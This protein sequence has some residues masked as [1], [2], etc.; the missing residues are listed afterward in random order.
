MAL[1]G[2]RR[3]TWRSSP[4]VTVK[5]GNAVDEG[6]TKRVN[7]AAPEGERDEGGRDE[8]EGGRDEGERD[9]DERDIAEA[10]DTDL[11]D[12]VELGPE[13]GTPGR[14]VPRLTDCFNPVPAGG[15]L[16]SKFGKRSGGWHAGQD[17]AP[18]RP[19][20]QGVAVHAISAGRVLTAQ[21][22]ALK[23]H[24]GLGVVIRHPSGISSYYGHLA[25]ARV[26]AGDTV[27][28]GQLVG[29]MGFTGNTRPAGAQGTHLHL[30]VIV[31]GSFVDPRSFLS[32]NG[33]VI[34]KPSSDTAPRP[35]TGTVRPDDPTSRLL[36]AGYAIDGPEGVVGAV[37]AYQRT[38]GLRDD[39]D[40][41][42]V[43]ERHYQFTR[44]LQAALNRWKAVRP[45][46]RV[47]GDLGT[48]TRQALRQMQGRNGL[49]VTGEPDAATRRRLEV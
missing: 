46:L 18:P 8:G 20:Q 26:S 6:S 44:R 41:G 4:A 13:W 9:E 3:Q 30:G 24:T 15:R 47:D 40:W 32:A 31:N 38:N 19:A 5:G 14:A 49:A 2:G 45:K 11:L 22:K 42:P 37:K 28:A 43:T 36:G 29:I 48:L 25:E 12:S 7:E 23:G 1:P 10:D 21:V 17:I 16:T 27:A 33:V 34:G 39:G 35:D